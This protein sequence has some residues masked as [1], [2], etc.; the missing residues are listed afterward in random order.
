MRKQ[1]KDTEQA[2]FDTFGNTIRGRDYKLEGL[3]V[4]A[5]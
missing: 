2:G 1:N 3:G 4:F 5:R